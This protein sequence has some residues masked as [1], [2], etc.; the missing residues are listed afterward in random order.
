MNIRFSIL[1]FAALGFV[2]PVAAEEFSSK[3]PPLS[4]AESIATME[5]QAGY[6]ITPVLTEPQIHEPSAIA[7]DGN[8]R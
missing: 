7:W 3:A 1:L 8:G 4:P 2:L 5:I 6:S